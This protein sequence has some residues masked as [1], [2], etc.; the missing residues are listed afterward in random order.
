[1]DFDE[2]LSLDDSRLSELFYLSP[3]PVIH[4]SRYA[5]LEPLL[6]SYCKRLPHKGMSRRKLYKEYISEHPDGYSLSSFNRFIQ[7]HMG[8]SCSVMHLEHKTGDKLSIVDADSGETIA[9]EV[10][11]AI[12]PC[13]QLTYVEA[14]MSQKKEDLITACESA[15]HY[16]G[17]TPLAIVPDNQ[18]AAAT[19]SSRYEATLNDDSASFTEHYGCTI[20]PARAYKPRDKALVEGAVKLIY[21]SIYP[22]LEGR[23]FHDLPTLNSAIR[24]ALEIHNSPPFAGRNYN[25][26]E[27]FEEVGRSTLGKLNP[28]RYELRKSAVLTVMKNGHIRLSQDAHYYNILCQY[29]GRKVKVAYTSTD[30][31]IY[32]NYTCIASHKRSYARFKYTTVDEHRPAHHRYTADWNPDKFISEAGVIHKDVADYISKVLENKP[33]PE[34]AYKSCVGILSF[35]RRVGLQRL[36]NACRWAGSYGLYNYPAIEKILNNRQDEI[37]LPEDKTTLRRIPSHENIWG[38]EYFN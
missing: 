19:K 23:I 2:V 13:S 26:R 9:V 24:A 3:Q 1:M 29:I 11:V 35:A 32:S 33:Y 34:Q 22:C 36:I 31:D 37:P 18:K 38:K 5:V 25:R 14:T 12:L 6:P 7:R 15:L 17:G 27:Q 8:M 20:M 30:V 4:D 10:F 21:R 16:F 28:I